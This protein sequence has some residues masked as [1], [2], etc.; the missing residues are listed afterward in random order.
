MGHQLRH[1]WVSLGVRGASPSVQRA[2]GWMEERQSVGKTREKVVGCDR[3]GCD[4]TLRFD[5][6]DPQGLGRSMEQC[7]NPKCPDHKPHPMMR[8]VLP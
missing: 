5:V 2:L 7:S 1:P 4:G 8:S 6:R 3:S